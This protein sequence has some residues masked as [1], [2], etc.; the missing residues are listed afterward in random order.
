MEG[1]FSEQEP[2]YDVTY[3]IVILPEF[4]SLPFPSVDLPEKVIFWL[5]KIEAVMCI[6]SLVLYSTTNYKYAG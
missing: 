3:E 1:G 6:L 2:E 4:L 5:Y